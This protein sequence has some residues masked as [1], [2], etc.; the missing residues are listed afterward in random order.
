M[1]ETVEAAEAKAT[2]AVAEK[3]AL[4]LAREWRDYWAAQG[5]FTL[6]K[7][8][9]KV[10]A[11]LSERSG[12][13]VERLRADT[14]AISPNAK[15]TLEQFALRYAVAAAGAPFDK[16]ERLKAELEDDAL[17]TFAYLARPYAD[18]ALAAEAE[19]DSLRAQRDAY[20]EMLEQAAIMA[21]QAADYDERC[22]GDAAT[23]AANGLGDRIR[24]LATGTEGKS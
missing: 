19:R 6:V 22:N 17:Q 3:D 1:S 21:D 8:T 10:I 18:R 5:E 20:K 24:A 14:T 16:V 15:T 2:D 12:E 11:A 7:F 13:E 9:D 23:G 4:T